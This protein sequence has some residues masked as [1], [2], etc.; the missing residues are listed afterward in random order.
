MTSGNDPDGCHAPGFIVVSGLGCCANATI[1]PEVS[2]RNRAGRRAPIRSLLVLFAAL[3]GLPAPAQAEEAAPVVAEAVERVE[4]GLRFRLALPEG[5]PAEKL[6]ALDAGE[7][8]GVTWE[9]EVFRDRKMW[10]NTTVEKRKIEATALFDPVTRRYTLEHRAGK[11]LLETREAGSRD[12]ALAWLDHLVPVE[13]AKLEKPRVRWRARAILARRLVMLFVPTTDHTG[14][15]RGE[16]DGG[17]G[18]S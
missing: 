12:E 1:R 14:W 11:E 7:T 13:P 3:A 18:E 9:L 15:A 4:E 2:Q 6:Q 16:L 5:L 8:V 10:F 17:G